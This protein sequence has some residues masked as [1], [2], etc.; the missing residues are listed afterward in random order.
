MLYLRCFKVPEKIKHRGGTCDAV[1][2]IADRSKGHE[3]IVW[4]ERVDRLY[5][6]SCVCVCV[7]VC[8]YVSSLGVYNPQL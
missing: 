5:E 1:V 4:R 8:V 6:Q 2:D 3:A 7:C